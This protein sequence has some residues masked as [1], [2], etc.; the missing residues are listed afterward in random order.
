MQPQTPKLIEVFFSY[1]HK[2]MEWRNKLDEHLSFLKREKKIQ[3][4]YDG[5]IQAG[6]QWRG[7]IETH[8]NT[9]DVILLLISASFAASEFCYSLEMNRAMERHA[10]GDALVI[11]ILL[12]PCDWTRAPFGA[13][14][15]L[16][17][18]TAISLAPNPEE[19]FYNVARRIRERIEELLAERFVEQSPATAEESSL[20]DQ[21]PPPPKIDFVPRQD[22][23]GTDIVER[24]KKELTQPQ[25]R[26]IALWGEGGVGKT[27]IAAEVVR[28]LESVFKERIVW[29]SAEKRADFTYSTLLNEIAVQLGE[30]GLTTLAPQPKEQAVRDLIAG[31]PTLIILDNFET[32]L[33]GEQYPCADFLATRAHCASLITTRQQLSHEAPRH[34]HVESMS[35]DE[36]RLFV[37]RWIEQEAHDPR[38]FDALG[39][40]EIIK[41]ADARPYVMQW[42]L[43]QID[44]ALEPRAVL[45][46]LAAGEGEVDER[47]FKRSFELPQLGDDGRAALLALS[48]FT[49]SASREALAEVAGFGTDGIRLNEATKRLATLRLIRTTSGG[50][51]L[52]IEGL[53]R[54][55]ARARLLKDTS[56]AE[57]HQR[58]VAHFLHYAQAHAK[59]TP[60]DFAALEAEKDNILNAMDVAFN[61]EDWTSVVRLMEAM[62]SD[63]VNGLLTMHGYWDEAIRRGEQALKAAHNLQDEATVARFAHNT[64][65]TFQSRGELEEARRLYNE[66]LEIAK[67]LSN[68]SSIAS[69]LHELGRLAQDQ[70]DLE[71]ARRLYNE[72]LEIKKRLGNQSG[73]ATTL[74]HLAILAQDQ[75]ELEEARRLYNESLKIAKRL[76]D[77]RIILSTLHELGRLA[78][79]QGMLEEARRFYDES[80]EISKRLGDQNNF[81]NTLH[82]LGRL[83]QAKGTFEEARRLYEESLEIKKRLGA[84]SGIAISLHALGVLAMVQWK[85]TEA[86]R[87][88]EESLEITKRL[89]DK[90]NIALLF[91][92]MGLLAEVEGQ[93]V[94]AK[95]LLSDALNIFE[96][97]GSPFA[98]RTRE[99]LKRVEDKSS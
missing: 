36:A 19:A 61:L 20:P 42:V 90:S 27:T 35:N 5:M 81:A 51:R 24:L 58:F 76:G 99:N 12:H 78:Q 92:N 43:A 62:N 3:S 10:A 59:T 82:E 14:Q 6:A 21:I 74:H 34:I 63:G 2:D 71:E 11:P 4:W 75:G 98:E 87:L 53:T 50:E 49:P 15:A 13:L 79:L 47:V 41:A 97:L 9:A 57:F 23:T 86:R 30:P 70:G 68:E 22:R 1:S 39:H 7:E 95:Q 32:V 26:L 73:I 8:L 33:P 67:R 94:E 66:S 37:T 64:A 91:F 56:T 89:D 69:T 25:K 38:A 46:E 65:I 16:P 17:G 40:D 55:Q 29:A 85:L 54:S 77:Q 18:G 45:N 44:L 96:K 72:S 28:A 60:E 52:T 48:L 88:Y 80:L 93:K 31:A 83:A 84:Q